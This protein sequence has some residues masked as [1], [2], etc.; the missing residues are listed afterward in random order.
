M[1]PENEGE[2]PSEVSTWLVIPY[3]PGDKGIPNNVDRPI[4]PNKATYWLCPAIIIDGTPGKTS[5][6]RGV[7]TAVTVDVVNWGA[8]SLTAPVQVRI[9]WANPA[10]SFIHAQPFGQAVL[11]APA[12]TGPVRSREIIGTIPASAPAHVCLLV[13]VAAP[14]DGSPAGSVPDP[15]GDRHWAQ[16]NLTEAVTDAE[17][18]FQLTVDVGN[19]FD[20]DMFVRLRVGALHEGELLLL[21]QR[22]GRDIHTT[23][24]DDVQMRLNGELAEGAINLRAGEQ[25][26]LEIFG[27]IRNLAPG[28][29]VAITVTQT[30]TPEGSKMPLDGA[31]GVLVTF[32]ER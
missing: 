24:P 27:R 28:E 10:L 30:G 20:R 8:G 7:P 14:M 4:D 23:E 26:P 18:A 13:H 22:L 31:V 21:A 15:A 19:P 12:G 11:L 3:Y 1:P 25:I 16:F 32:P 2:R 9:W 5:F 29:T 17:G 6:V